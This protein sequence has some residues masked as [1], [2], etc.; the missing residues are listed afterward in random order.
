MKKMNKVL[1]LGGSGNFGKRIAEGLSK[2]NINVV[3]AGR[4]R[5]NLEKIASQLNID[6]I[7]FDINNDFD[8][9][10]KKI[11]PK[12]V[13]NTCGP[14]QNSDYRIAQLCIKQSVHYIDLADGRDFVCNITQ[15]N[16]LAKEKNITIIS[17]ASTVPC[18]SSCVIERFKDEFSQIDSLTYGISPGQKNSPGIATAESILSYLGKP[19]KTNG[20]KIVYGWQD[21]YRQDYPDLGKRWM[22]NCE[23]PDLD[24]FPIEY[25]IKDVKFS[26]GMENSIVH[27]SIWLVSWMKRLGLPIELR[28]HA[29]LLLKIN[30]YFNHF[31][32]ENGGMHM[33][34][35]GKNK[36][37]KDHERR[38]FIIAKNGD[39]PQIPCAPSIILTEK[40]L[41][42]DINQ[43]FAKPCISIITLEEYM[44]S[45]K[46]FNINE[47]IL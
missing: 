34:L 43:G 24:I 46:E 21:I 36:S 10:L 37:G 45:L 31:G 5:E 13:I 27:L 38:W 32:T 44:N 7:L 42:G 33:I 20:D 18:L 29:N 4:N 22:G 3:I 39:G 1:I 11:N 23:I 6:F 9:E 19:I 12:I 26:A 16:E 47:Y 17:G 14:F 30:N 15:L 40:I 25:K 35:K 2:K 8:K 28:N 41:S